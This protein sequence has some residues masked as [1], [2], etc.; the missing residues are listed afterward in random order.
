MCAI[1]A[2]GTYDPKKGGHLIL[3]DWKLVIEFPPGCTILIP[4]AAVAHGNI[5]VGKGEVRKS[6]TQYCAGGLLRWFRYGCRTEEQFERQDRSGW[7]A[8]KEGAAKRW[9]EACGMFSKV[10]ELRRDCMENLRFDDAAVAMEEGCA[11]AM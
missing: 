5:A 9:E 8:M 3:W 11:G 2:L 10:S 1:H 6:V 4:S 7:R